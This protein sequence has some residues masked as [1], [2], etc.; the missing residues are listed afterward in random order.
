MSARPSIIAIAAGFVL[1]IGVSVGVA[2]ILS[3]GAGPVAPDVFSIGY[4]GTQQAF[5]SP[6]SGTPFTTSGGSISGNALMQVLSDPSNAFCSGC[7]D[8]IVQIKNNPGSTANITS[9]TLSGYASFQTDVGYDSQS[10]GGS[11]ECGPADQGFCN[12][13]GQGALGT[14]SRDATGN[15]ITFNFA[16][17][18]LAPGQSSVDFVV[19]TNSNSFA[20]ATLSVV[21]ANGSSAA[22]IGGIFAPPAA[23]PTP[24]PT[25]SPS[26]TPAPP[27]VVLLGV[28]LLVVIPAFLF[29]R[30]YLPQR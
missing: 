26:A 27:T 28:A 13:S 16:G 24:P 25:P 7:L 14:V 18:G 30:R 17:S 19:E 11:T 15:V 3:P 4:S 23:V 20:S 8:F 2:A 12:V 29:A 9:L 6:S 21:G 22:G 1:A 10:V 5:T